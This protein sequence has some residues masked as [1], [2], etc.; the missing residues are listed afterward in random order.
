M[1]RIETLTPLQMPTGS[2]TQTTPSPSFLPHAGG[3]SYHSHFSGVHMGGSW[4][5]S[6][7]SYMMHPDNLQLPAPLHSQQHLH[8]GMQQLNPSSSPIFHSPSGLDTRGLLGAIDPTT[9]S[10][11]QSNP[12]PSIQGDEDED[13]ISDDRDDQRSVK[14]RLILGRRDSR[15]ESPNDETD[16]DNTTKPVTRNSKIQHSNSFS[17]ASGTKRLAKE[18]EVDRSRKKSKTASGA[19][20]GGA[21]RLSREPSDAPASAPPA[22]TTLGTR[23]TMVAGNDFVR[24]LYNLL[25][26]S[27]HSHILE[28]GSAG[29]SFV[30]KD[31]AALSQTILPRSFSHSNFSSFVRQLN[32]YDFHKVKSTEREQPAGSW[33]FKHPHFQRDRED[34]LEFVRRKP[35]K[36]KAKADDPVPQPPATPAVG[37]QRSSSS[38]NV[39]R[40]NFETPKKESQHPPPPA[41]NMEWERG[42][43]HLLKELT[44]SVVTLTH[45]VKYLTDYNAELQAALHAGQRPGLFAPA[46]MGDVLPSTLPTVPLPS[47]TAAA[48]SVLNTPGESPA[49][50]QRKHELAVMLDCFQGLTRLASHV[51]PTLAA[52]RMASSRSSAVPLGGNADAGR[53]PKAN[54]MRNLPKFSWGKTPVV[55]LVDDDLNVIRMSTNILERIGCKVLAV[56]DGVDAVNRVQEEQQVDLI[57]MDI[58]MPTMDGIDAT[59]AIRRF[60]VRVPIISMTTNATESDVLNYYNA[61]MNEVLPKPFEMKRLCDLLS[62]Y[63]NHYLG[64]SRNFPAQFPSP[65]AGLSSR[66]IAELPEEDGGTSSSSTSCTSNAVATTLSPS[67]TLYLDELSNLTSN[68]TNA[69]VA[70]G[71]H[72]D[73]HEINL[74]AAI[75]A[76]TVASLPMGIHYGAAG[77]SQSGVMDLYSTGLFREEG[78][79]PSQTE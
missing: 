8:A 56:Q 33:E 58:V 77:T 68:S 27:E 43:Y 79:D 38:S 19:V 9:Y 30:I 46:P 66:A 48:T 61:G 16:S 69:T 13:D 70:D 72:L 26:M 1:Q 4:S 74:A 59:H 52:P 63:C 47:V 49:R 20:P 37:L 39:L 6:S 76:L 22:L 28:W 67:L 50:A 25:D 44:T 40:G 62:K 75:H 18:P 78:T 65:S 11:L 45:Q 31:T 12:S 7:N 23:T 55:L 24:K 53:R 71:L 41:I 35:N 14:S 34:F 64:G 10:P 32:K 36:P 73:G 15:L 21:G 60:N 54:G 5:P 17:F 2:V 57:L 29:D 42:L 51:G 3:P